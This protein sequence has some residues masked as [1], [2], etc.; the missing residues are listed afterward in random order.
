MLTD[1]DIL[2]RNLYKSMVGLNDIQ[3][4]ILNN[5]TFMNKVTINS[6]LNISGPV[7]F[8]NS[9]T[10]NSNINI[11]NNLLSKSNITTLNTLYI[12][13]LTIMNNNITN[14]SILNIS[15]NAYINNLSVSGPIQ[16][17]NST[18]INNILN[19][20][21]AV[22]QGT[23]LSSIIQSFN[24]NKLS[25]N[26]NTIN[27]G[28]KNSNIYIQGT[29]TYIGTTQL[30]T[31]DK[32]ITLNINSSIFQ[33]IDTGYNSG[34]QIMGTGG[35]G[36]IQSSSD[37]LQYVIKAPMLSN[38]G[39][40]V[41]HNYNNNLSIEGI[42]TLQN[43]VFINS[44]LYVSNVSIIQNPMTI[45][46]FLNI[47]GNS[48]IYNNISL[49]S[50]LN[51]SNN[52]IITGNISI[53]N[54]L[55]ISTKTILNNAYI[56][57]NIYIYNNS[58]IN[59]NFLLNNLYISNNSIINRTTILSKLNVSG[60]SKIM[61]SLV[62][63]SL[64]VIGTSIINN[65]ISIRT[66]LLASGKTIINNNISIKSSLNISGSTFI[67]GNVSIL[68][69]INILGL[70][71]AKLKNYTLNSVAKN[72]GIPIGGLYRNGGIVVM[73]L[74]DVAPTIYLSGSSNLSIDL[75]TSY[76][77]PGAYALTYN[78]NYISVYL[79][80]IS[81]YISNYS[82]NVL[83]NGTSTLI[84]NTSTLPYGNY[85]A[86]YKATDPTGLVGY[87]YRS[88]NILYQLKL[89]LQPISSTSFSTLF[90]MGGC[91]GIVGVWYSGETY[92]AV[93]NSTS[94]TGLINTSIWISTDYYNW[95]SINLSS[96]P[97]ISSLNR[98]IIN[99]YVLLNLGLTNGL[100]VISFRDL[101]GNWYYFIYDSVNNTLRA[102]PTN[103]TSMGF[104]IYKV[105]NMCTYR[106]GSYTWY[107]TDG[108]TWTFGSLPQIGNVLNQ[109]IYV[110]GLWFS[111]VYNTTTNQC[112]LY[113]TSDKI[114]WTL[115]YDLT[116]Q[117]RNIG[118]TTL[119]VDN[120]GWFMCN[121]NMAIMTGKDTYGTSNILFTF[122]S[123]DGITWTYNQLPY[124]P[125]PLTG[126]NNPN[127]NNYYT[128]NGS[129]WSGSLWII[130]F[131]CTF[132]TYTAQ[133]GNIYGTNLLGFFYS[134]DGINWN[135]STTLFY[136][137][138]SGVSFPNNNWKSNYDGMRCSMANG[139]LILPLNNQSSSSLS[140]G[141]WFSN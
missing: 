137:N 83:I 31:S 4:D 141:L 132:N 73:R 20:N 38:I 36:F 51:I 61:N 21:I 123:Y 107:F 29:S 13:G 72:A 65:N 118:I 10:G 96:F 115:S 56:N 77:D 45:N 43:N 16:L 5:S 53:M 34:I 101:P 110:N 22:I 49:N 125:V 81:S 71:S 80:S 41:T 67:N 89:S 32:L 68:S 124:V 6:S 19:A 37:G 59:N 135:V 127:N 91:I 113:S 1:V 136:V 17:F 18:T 82:V 33:G 70:M 79:T 85:T 9:V 92:M 3:I 126:I 47:S 109:I 39:Y 122:Y 117:L 104:Y 28:N 7:I 114:N 129:F 112:L 90:S 76:T 95:I 50:I 100:F 87:N 30:N 98:P 55:N 64:S 139:H 58:I 97:Q 140:K 86:T 12:S 69:N 106:Y 57:S 15:G 48:I 131:Q 11:P 63:S 46:S 42:S 75:N 99:S 105:N 52:S 93:P 116:P 40:I 14:F 78:N 25:I 35:T 84:T 26:A 8:N 88:L 2:L 24:T 27:I 44:S 119:G 102:F 66:N 94:T 130:R 111:H 108:Y 23:F 103:G 138:P 54:N 128:I 120:V 60:T 134:S 133:T 62:L 121:D 74:N